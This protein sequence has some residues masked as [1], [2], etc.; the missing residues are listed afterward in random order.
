MYPS[1]A[2]RPDDPG[3]NLSVVDTI[4]LPRSGL[5]PTWVSRISWGG[6]F[7]G[8]FV[9]IAIQLGLSSLSIWA[10]FGL[11]DLT[12][13][14]SIQSEATSVAVWIGVSSLVS[15]FVAGIVAARLSNSSDLRGGLWHGLVSWGVG[16]TAM[17]GLSTLGLSGVLGFG[18]SGSSVLRAIPGLASDAG[19]GLTR[20]TSASSTYAGYYLL[21]LS[22]G[23]VTALVGGWLGSAV[24]GRR[25]RATSSSDVSYEDETR[26]P[27]AA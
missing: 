25:A 19:Q 2:G 9:A 22:L 24:L 20:T 6:V 17:T 21:F 16:V 18:L 23:L 13:V 7:A 12:S 27:R 14:A 4:D 3:R 26:T 1:R 8:V 10:G 5:V 15:L 11:A